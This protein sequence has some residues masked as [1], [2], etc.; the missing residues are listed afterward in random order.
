MLKLW[1]GIGTTVE[2]DLLTT[3]RIFI[4]RPLCLNR[5]KKYAKD[6]ILEILKKKIKEWN[7]LEHQLFLYSYLLTN[8]MVMNL[9]LDKVK[10]EDIKVERMDRLKDELEKKYPNLEDAIQ[11]LI[12]NIT[13]YIMKLD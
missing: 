12:K 5:P 9:E 2:C 8:A 11:D 3:Y 7:A 13:N 10:L 4:T 1:Y 6:A